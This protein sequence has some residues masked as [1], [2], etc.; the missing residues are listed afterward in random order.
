MA[1][2]A[3]YVGTVTRQ[4]TSHEIAGVRPKVEKVE[5]TEKIMQKERVK[6]EVEP[7]AK[8]ENPE[9]KATAKR[10]G[11]PK[12]F[13]AFATIADN[14]DTVQNGALLAKEVRAVK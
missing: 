9:Q 7:W 13:Q 12:D 14:P 2:R 3:A 6:M 4:D 10:D 8:M 1:A 5:K 11:I